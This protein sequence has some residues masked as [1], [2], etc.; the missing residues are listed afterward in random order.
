MQRSWKPVIQGHQFIKL[1]KMKFN[2]EISW[3]HKPFDGSVH[4]LLF[5]LCKQA[6][7]QI[8]FTN[9]FNYIIFQL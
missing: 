2:A 5:W 8:G 3:Q 4:Q 1:V 9:S 6:I 7:N